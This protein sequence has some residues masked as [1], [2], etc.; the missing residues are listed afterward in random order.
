MPRW[1]NRQTRQLQNLQYSQFKSG[2]GHHAP[3]A[4]LIERWTLNP[5]VGGLNPSRCTNFWT[6]SSVVEQRPF[7][8]LVLRSIRRGFS[9]GRWSSD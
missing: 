1:R 4:Q 2:V 9:M 3:V 7:N 5:T 6:L 8:P